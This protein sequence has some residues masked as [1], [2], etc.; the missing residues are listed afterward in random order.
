MPDDDHPHGPAG[1]D[2]A[3]PDADDVAAATAPLV[4]EL[5]TIRRDLHMHP[6]R[7]GSEHRTTA[8]IVERLE[9]AGLAPKTLSFGTGLTCDVGRVDGTS[10]LVALRAD[11]DALSMPDEKDVPYRSRVDG[12]SHACGHDVH[13]AV[14][15]GAG[16]VLAQ[17]LDPADAPGGVRLIFEPAE[18][19]VPG[20]AVDVID[21]GHLDGVDAVFGV[22]CDPKTNLG[23]V[24]VRSGPITSA[25]DMIEVSLHGPGGH[26]ARPKLTV[27]LVQVAA[28]V[29]VELP[30]LVARRA[31]QYGDLRVVFGALLSGDAH[32]VIP[33]LARLRGSMRTPDRAAW[34]VALS[35]LESSLNDLVLPTGATWTLD[36]VRGVP[37]VVNDPDATETLAAA[38]REVVGTD[39]VVDAVRSWGGD[40]FA[41][42][43]ENRP[44]SYARL[45][46]HDPSGIEPRIDLHAGAFDVDE[47]AIAIGVRVLAGTALRALTSPR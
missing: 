3:L 14:V 32:N 38:A 44:G 6:E 26:T 11:I 40:S 46:T 23:Q 34:E 19:T 37:P 36:H 10:P 28:H 27:D 2:G 33:T 5:V 8:R 22:H 16:L 42:Y 7:S 4:A 41:W 39:G 9:R 47:R 18:E 12:L 1:G 25:A 17:L 24:G 43:L 13:T 35:V 21:E 20:G 30:P 15:L 31:A 45:G 29:A